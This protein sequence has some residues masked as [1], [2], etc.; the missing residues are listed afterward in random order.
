MLDAAATAHRYRID[1]EQLTA[2]PL[3]AARRGTSEATD[4]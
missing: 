1:I 3:L 2:E 4:K